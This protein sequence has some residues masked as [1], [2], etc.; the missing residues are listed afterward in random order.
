M[1][2]TPSRFLSQLAG[3]L[4]GTMLAGCGS[5]TLVKDFEHTQVGSLAEGESVVILSDYKVAAVETDADFIDCVT[6]SLT[7]GDGALRV[8][9][10]QD[11]IDGMY[12]YFEA[13]TAPANVGAVDRL[14]YDLAARDRMEELNVRYIVWIEGDTQTVD[15]NGS[16]SCTIGPG[17]GGCFG[18]A[19]WTDR[20]SYRAKI[21]DFKKGEETGSF[22]V[23]STGTSHLVGVVLPIP[24]LA[25]VESEACEAMAQRVTVA[26]N[27]GEAPSLLRQARNG[28][29]FTP[30]AATSQ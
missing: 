7:D 28:D 5:T 25:S 12:P 30:A 15:K 10:Q 4:A 23:D 17:G 26:V 6:E 29:K 20:G 19:S 2:Q 16:F 9:G 21:W 14:A 24:L 13:S 18:W 22:D 1:M 8:I 27:G 11:F 3:L